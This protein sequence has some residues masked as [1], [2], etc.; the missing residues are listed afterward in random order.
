MYSIIENFTVNLQY[1]TSN[2][3]CL[4]GAGLFFGILMQFVVIADSALYHIYEPLH[5][6]IQYAQVRDK[7]FKIKIKKYILL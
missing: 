2:K 4:Q 3:L 5:I 1:F 7:E 6:E